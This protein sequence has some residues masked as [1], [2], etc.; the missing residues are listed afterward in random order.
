M[1][2][3]VSPKIHTH[4]KR[5]LRLP[6][7]PQTSYIRECRLAPLGKDVCH[8][9]HW[10]T[11]LTTSV[12]VLQTTRRHIHEGRN[13]YRESPDSLKSKRD[14]ECLRTRSWVL[15]QLLRLSLRAGTYPLRKWVLHKV[16]YISSSF[17]YQYHLFS[18]RSCSSCLHLPPHIL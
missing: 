13:P 18:L 8:S 15:W 2:V 10:P 14:R 1:Y 9:R 11:F 7:L 17:K 3:W 5:D 4:K 16:R 12:H 6:P